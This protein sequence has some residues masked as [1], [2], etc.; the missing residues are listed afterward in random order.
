MQ[1]GNGC[2]STERRYGFFS[3][4]P[5]VIPRSMATDALKFGRFISVAT[6]CAHCHRPVTAFAEVSLLHQTP[7]C[8]SF[9]WLRAQY[10]PWLLE[11]PLPSF[12]LGGLGIRLHFLAVSN[13]TLKILKVIST[14]TRCGLFVLC[15]L[16]IQKCLY[17]SFAK[18]A[19]FMPSPKI[20]PR[21]SVNIFFLQYIW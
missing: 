16:Q 17:C 2:T 1:L 9:P 18:Y 21:A 13:L 6:I 11:A 5:Y 15:S 20:P 14:H 19:F 8:E 4:L 7:P 12:L 10:L 3:S